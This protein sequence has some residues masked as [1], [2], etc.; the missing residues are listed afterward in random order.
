MDQGYTEPVGEAWK[1]SKEYHQL[2][3]FLGV[4]VYD[5]EDAD[6]HKKVSALQEWGGGD[7]IRKVL[8]EVAKLRR[9]LGVQVIGKQLVTQLYQS[10]RLK[11]DNERVNPQISFAIP[12][13]VKKETPKEAKEKPTSLE[14]VITQAVQNTIAQAVKAAVGDTKFLNQAVKEAVK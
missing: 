12:R 4:N 2:S 3:D 9:E 6:L 14:G 8:T 11:Q 5:R 10:V 13:P 1:Y 7:D